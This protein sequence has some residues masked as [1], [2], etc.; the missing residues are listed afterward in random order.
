MRKITSSII[1]IVV[2]GAILI[3]LASLA[4]VFYIIGGIL[5][6]AYVIYA[7]FTDQLG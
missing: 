3:L 7:I 2:A 5:L 4:Q 1:S 6:V